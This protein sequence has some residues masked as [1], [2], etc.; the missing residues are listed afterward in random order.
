[1]RFNP[2][3]REQVGQCVFQTAVEHQ[4]FAAHFLAPRALVVGR[5]NPEVAFEQL[6]DW[7][8]RSRLAMGHRIGFEQQAASHG[9]LL[10]LVEQSGLPQPRLAHHPDNLSVAGLRLRQRPLQLFHLIL[11]ADELRQPAAGCHLQSR[12]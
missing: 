5:L 2:E 7:E 11:A 9:A 12:A 4:H 10:E 1:M 6:D 8:I 3:Q